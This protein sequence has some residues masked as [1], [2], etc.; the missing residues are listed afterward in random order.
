MQRTPCHCWCCLPRFIL[1][2]AFPTCLGYQAVTINLE[3]F[4][5]ALFSTM[6]SQVVRRMHQCTFQNKLLRQRAADGRQDLRPTC[7]SGHVEFDVSQSYMTSR[8]Y[9]A[10]EKGIVRKACCEAIWPRS[11]LAQAGYDIDPRCPLCNLELD[12][13][14]HRLYECAVREAVSMRAISLPKDFVQGAKA[15]GSGHP[16]YIL[17]GLLSRYHHRHE[18]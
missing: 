8:S 16:L 14:W 15:H 5:P 17:A 11:R 6:L 13:C 7:G 1:E 10:T 9:T 3:Q 2:M 4:A 12:I 18:T